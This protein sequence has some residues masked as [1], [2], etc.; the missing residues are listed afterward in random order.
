MGKKTSKGVSE[1]LKKYGK[2][3]SLIKGKNVEKED[4]IFYFKAVKI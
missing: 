4:I 2:G 1:I 3:K